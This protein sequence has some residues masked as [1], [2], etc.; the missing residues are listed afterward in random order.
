MTRFEHTVMAVSVLCGFVFEVPVLMPV[1]AVLMFLSGLMSGSS[2]VALLYQTVVFPRLKPA[3]A[4]EDAGPWRTAAYATSAVLGLGT[5]VLAVGDAGLAW[6]FGLAAAVLG[7]LTGV[8]GVC[9]GCR[10]HGRRPSG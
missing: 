5:L 3:D 8:G 9:V 1:W 6:V 10:L 4:E 2:P 7:A